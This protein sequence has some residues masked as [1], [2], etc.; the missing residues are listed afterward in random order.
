MPVRFIE[1]P[2]E[3]DIPDYFWSTEF[4]QGKKGNF[5]YK[6]PE[7]LTF[8]INKETGRETGWCLWEDRDLERPCAL[9]VE[10]ITVDC[11]ENPLLCEIANDCGDVEQHKFR[12]LR[13]WVVLHQAPE[14]YE[15]TQTL[16]DW[17]P[18]DIY[19]E[20]NITYDFETGEFN[21]PIKSDYDKTIT[22]DHF[23]KYRD[24]LLNGSD[25]KVVE[26]M[27]EN[28]KTKWKNYRNLLRNAPVALS[29]FP[30]WVAVHMM[31]RSPESG[32]RDDTPPDLSDL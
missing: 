19:D 22:W 9:D 25:G 30:P 27:P 11:K 28:L 21:L 15:S 12:T 4:T 8:E 16:N 13:T 29:Q 32:E 2:F 5:V 6:G 14:G 23:R 1:V 20:Y 7:F 24:D 3:Y 18:R 26:D 31:P 10:R 17:E